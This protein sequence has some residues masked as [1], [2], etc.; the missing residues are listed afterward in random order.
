MR[1]AIARRTAVMSMCGVALGAGILSSGCALFRNIQVPSEVFEFHYQLAPQ[2][3]QGAGIYDVS[4]KQAGGCSVSPLRLEDIARAVQHIGGSLGFSSLYDCAT[5]YVIGN[6][7]Q[8]LRDEPL[9][10]FGVQDLRPNAIRIYGNRGLYQGAAT[11]P[12]GMFI[13]V[14]SG[15][16]VGQRLNTGYAEIYHGGSGPIFR[17]EGG[18]DPWHA[19]IHNP[20]R[21]TFFQ[22][23]LTSISDEKAEGEFECLARNKDD[24]TDSRLLIIMGGS[25]SLKNSLD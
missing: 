14:T 24:A 23:T 1:S 25:F 8:S 5:W 3:S 16:A 20:A 11:Q 9:I 7:A 18:D 19:N 12:T 4:R 13:D 15:L 21:D 22:L 6:D 17:C 10:Q 2:A